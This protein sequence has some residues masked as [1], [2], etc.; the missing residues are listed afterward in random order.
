MKLW[1][2]GWAIAL[3]MAGAIALAFVL[4]SPLSHN[5]PQ[6]A[7][8]NSAGLV[9]ATSGSEA[10]PGDGILQQ[11]NP[12]VVTI[13]SQR[14]VGSGTLVDPVGLVLTSRHVLQDSRL[15]RVKTAAGTTYTAQVI[16]L[17]LQHD[18]A[19]LRLE[20]ESVRFPVVTFADRVDLQPGQVVYAIGSPA[21][22]PGTLTQG[23]FTRFTRH[24]SLQLS[25]GLL[26][27]G[28]S[29]G[30]LLNPQGEV[31]GI[32]KGLL[33]DNSGLASPVEPAKALI[34]KQSRS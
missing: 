9:A 8:P 27:P 31:I 33:E 13:Y 18:L 7:N 30:P 19:L 15:V 25:P 11:V 21:N 6:P 34:A 32:N 26:A 2:L 10:Q 24:G 1:Q 17:D 23:R 29:G 14:E 5:P 16:D 20:A 3:G 28:N 22:K 12:A 4:P